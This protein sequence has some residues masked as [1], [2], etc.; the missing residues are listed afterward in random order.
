MF[1]ECAA[2]AGADYLVTGDK[3]HLLSLKVAA[4]VPIVPASDFLRLL[5]VPE[6]PM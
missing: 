6:N 2:A 4:G 5:G 1:I 3:S